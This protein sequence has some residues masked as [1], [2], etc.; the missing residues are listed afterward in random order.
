MTSRKVSDKDYEHIFKVWNKFEIKTIKDYHDL[1]LKCDVLL[2]ADVFEKFRDGSL[3]D[4]GLCPSQYSR[5]P[6]LSWDA[7]LNMVRVE[8]E[9]ISDAEIY[10]F[11]EKSMRRRV[12]YISKRYSKASIKYLKTYNLQQESKQFIYLDTNNLY[13]CTMSQ[14]LLIS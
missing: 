11:F 10:L 4:Y 6:D 12:S 14:F 1:Y 13:G 8:I 7:K 3:K 2:L 9:L 5:A